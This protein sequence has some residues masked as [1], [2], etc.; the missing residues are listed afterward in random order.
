MTSY[1]KADGL[2][3]T[4]TTEATEDVLVDSA[5]KQAVKERGK[6]AA[7]LRQLQQNSQNVL[8]SKQIQI[9][10]ARKQSSLLME[11]VKKHDDNRCLKENHKENGLCPFE[12]VTGRPMSTE[13]L[14]SDSLVQTDERLSLAVHNAKNQVLAPPKGSHGL[15]PNKW[16]KIKKTDVSQQEYRWERPIEDLL[17]TDT[18]VK[19]QGNNEW[20]DVNLPRDEG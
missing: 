14:T 15:V 16:V 11:D 6:H 10:L 9:E 20:I 7:A 17:V 3:E 18:A 2:H 5:A 4:S 19:A 12:H 8:H 13:N 1:P